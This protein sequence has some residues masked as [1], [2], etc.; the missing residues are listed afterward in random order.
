[1]ARCPIIYVESLFCDK[2][3]EMSP[4]KGFLNFMNHLGVKQH[5]NRS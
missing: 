3:C 1:M 2:E 4:S 5:Y